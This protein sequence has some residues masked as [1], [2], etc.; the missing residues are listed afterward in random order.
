MQA[1]LNVKLK[2]FLNTTTCQVSGWGLE[3]PDGSVRDINYTGRNLQRRVLTLFFFFFNRRLALLGN[4]W[5]YHII[6]FFFYTWPYFTQLCHLQSQCSF[7]FF[8][9]F[10]TSAFMVS[11]KYVSTLCSLLTAF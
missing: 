6:F 2:K 8:Y 3:L 11:I 7:F 5:S 4:T 10:V 9:K 1:R